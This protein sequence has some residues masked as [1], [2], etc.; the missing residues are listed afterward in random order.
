MN[1]AAA[2]PNHNVTAEAITRKSKSSFA[3]AFFSMPAERRRDLVTFYAFCRVIDDIADEADAPVAE[4]AARLAAWKRALTEPFAGEPEL[5]PAMRDLM[6]RYQLD[7]EIVALIIEGCASDLSPAHFETFDQLLGYCYRVASAVGLVCIE[8]F[9]CRD[10][11]AHRYAVS[12]GYALQL[13][14][15]LRDVAKDLANGGR[16]YLPAEDMAR[17]GV[18]EEDLRERQ[19]GPRFGSLMAFEAERAEALYAQ[20]LA[21]RPFRD[22][23][24]IM[25]A[26]MMRLIYYKILA[27]MRQDGFRVFEKTYRVG[28]V[29]KLAIALRVF[30]WAA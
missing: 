21:E 25:P 8:L 10:Q 22:R 12:L 28:K 26:E 1:A 15:I 19:G 14:N 20:A 5:A 13:T 3:F 24:A 27:G 29:G 9:G 30:L 2:A 6:E 4:R 23:R 16:I 18:T 17:F 11:G 7:R